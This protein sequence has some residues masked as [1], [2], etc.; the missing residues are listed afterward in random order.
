MCG[1]NLNDAYRCMCHVLVPR[2]DG[3]DIV[4]T[5][6]T[7]LFGACDA[8]AIDAQLLLQERVM[9]RFLTLSEDPHC[10]RQACHSSRYL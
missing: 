1:E 5:S 2:K 8:A 10:I 4:K 7:I 9:Q 3:R 6:A